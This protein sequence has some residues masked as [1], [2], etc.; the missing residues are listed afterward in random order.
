MNIAALLF[1]VAGRQPQ[2]PAVSDG[3]HAWSYG[4][5]VI[6]IS[7]LAG[8]LRAYGL[9][10]GADVTTRTVHGPGSTS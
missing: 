10:P 1:E 8:G 6:R 2:H 4:E 3:V 7:C 5:F 9:E